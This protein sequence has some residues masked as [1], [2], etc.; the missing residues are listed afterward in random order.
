MCR[1]IIVSLF[2]LSNSFLFSTSSISS[3][4]NSSLCHPHDASALLHFK[5]SFS[6]FNDTS[7]RDCDYNLGASRILSWKNG[8]DC[9]TWGGVT[10][11]KVTGNVI[12]L[13]L[14]CGQLRGIIHSNN[15]LFFLRHLRSLD[16]SYNDFSGSQLLANFGRFTSMRHLNLFHS[17]FD[18]QVPQE[19]S[20]LSQ[21]LSLD[22]SGNPNLK[23]ETWSLQRTTA[24]LTNLK[25]LR[26]C[27]VNMSFVQIHSLMNLSSSLTSLDLSYSGL[28]GKFPE[29]IFLLP[30]LQ[31]LSLSY[32]QNLTGFFPKSNWSTS[33]I[34]ELTL[35]RT[36]FSIDMSYLVR[37]LKFLNGLYLRTCTFIR[38]YPP[39][40]MAGNLSK[41]TLLD[42]SFNNFDGHIPWNIFLNLQQLISLDLSGNNF[43][44]QLPETCTNNSNQ[45]SFLCD[46]SQHQ[47]LDHVPMNLEYLDLSSNNLNGTIPSWLYSLPFL[48]HLGL[49]SNQFIGTIQ[50]FHYAS[51]SYLNLEGNKLH[52]A[53]PVSVFQQQNLTSLALGGNN[54]SGAI[55]LDQFSKLKNLEYLSL[56][57]NNLSLSFNNSDNYTFP[58]L[59]YLLLSS[60]NISEFPYFLRASEYLFLLELSQNKI[61]GNIPKWLWNVG[62][63]TLVFLNLSHNLLTGH[64]PEQLPWKYLFTFDIRSNFIQGHLPIPPPSTH[65]YFLSNN[66]LFGEIPSLI[67]ALT[68]IDFLDL[69]H[70][71]LNGSIPLCLGNLSYLLVLDLRMNMLDGTIPTTFSK[72]NSLINIALNG[73]RLK[74]PLP[75]AL[76]NCRHLEILD[77]GNNM[78][79]DTFPQWLESLPNLQ[80]LVLRS[81]KFHSSISSPNVRFPFQKLRIMD[82]SNNLFQG[83][84]PTGYFGNFS[85]MM[86][87]GRVDKLEY[88][89]EDHSYYYQDSATVTM[90]GFEVS[91][92]KIL[93]IFMT[94]DFS[95]NNF[96]GEI[97]EAVGILK[98]LK[99]F[100]LSH[101]KLYGHIPTSLRN[102]NNLEWLDL[103]SNYLYGEIPMQ[104]LEMTSLEVLNLSQNHLEGAIPSGN[105]FDT[106]RNDSYIGNLGLCGFPLTK[107]CGD[108]EAQ[109]PSPSANDD[110]EATNGFQWK[111]VYMGYGSGLVIGM[112]VGYMF[113]SD[114][115]LTC[116]MRKVGGGRWLKLL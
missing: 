6:I 111:Y 114:E 4:Y 31:V 56:S 77:V 83:L 46:S 48:K 7:Y 109:Q 17:S 94:I 115:R 82:L 35:S 16:L 62:V 105:Q 67:C 64:V 42:L 45:I 39:L 5:H 65:F 97:P 85:A 71:A 80:V 68:Y 40:V 86:H 72:G 61:Q 24:N 110:E 112:S 74:G 53:I 63:D 106:F 21:L 59:K 76:L 60:C 32:N 11:D 20:Y 2:V 44:G 91:F 90:K 12:Q 54:L 28:Q 75:R 15:T 29:K 26:L 50:E 47:L 95:K 98:S 69:S 3:F 73:N 51:L 100:N 43:V 88:M 1:L 66:Q 18:G 10:C 93:K 107:T 30:N 70:N 116:L 101:N 92:E 89:G 52:G 49:A 9:C 57:Y 8:T 14:H 36:A 55:S 33:P 27:F 113:Y 81:N 41:I 37:N 58:N 79:N 23:L 34:R 103:S 99:G 84:L 25:E 96:E 38:S 87:D 102:L 108:D 22:L 13:N 19:I 78:I 104:L